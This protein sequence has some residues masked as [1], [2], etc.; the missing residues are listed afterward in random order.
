MGSTVYIGLA[1]TSHNDTVLNTSTFTNV[2]LSNNAPT[3]ATAGGG[4][5]E[6]RDDDHDGVLG[7]GRRR[8]W[9]SESDLHLDRHDAPGR[10]GAA[11]LQRQRHQRREKH[12]GHLLQGRQL[13]LPRDDHRQQRADSF[14][15]DRHGRRQ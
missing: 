3:V 4:Q 7:S 5:S 12:D 6:S 8:P 9:R 1:L 2:S 11:D 10:R 13:R 14:Q 15:F